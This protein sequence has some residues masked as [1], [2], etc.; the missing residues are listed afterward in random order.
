MQIV[1]GIKKRPRKVLLYGTHGV[2]KTT[3]AAQAGKVIVLS[4]EDGGGDVGC[5]RTPLLKDLG[6]VN[7]CLSDL[8]TQPHDY[9][10]ACIDTLDW[11]E[12]L[13]FSTVCREKGIKNIE[14]V[15]YAKGYKLALTHWDFII[16]SLDH[17]MAA[18]DMGIILL[19]H[20]RIIKIEDPQTDT[21]TK[22]EP[23]LDKNICNHLQEWVDEVFFA[24][25]KIATAAKD[26]GF[27]KERV[28][29]I[30]LNERIVY[31]SENSG[32][33]AKRRIPMDDEMPLDFSH[34]MAAI[35]SAYAGKPVAPVVPV[36]SAAPI[37]PAGDIAGIVTN[38]H[39]KPQ[40]EPTPEW[41][42]A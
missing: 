8:I 35:L 20:T 32:F 36:A 41:A 25:H 40:T 34:Y 12:K 7:A 42:S 22:H 30:S 17:L 23:D 3:W 6:S 26:A 1:K 21:Y 27:G 39:S 24:R 13:I 28:R 11:L 4:T 9:Q 29:E 10:W 38:G 14:D 19:A 2:G 33:Y 37:E 16:H 5:D 31:T 15:P 18:R